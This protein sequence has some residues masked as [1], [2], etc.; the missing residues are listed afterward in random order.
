MDFAIKRNRR[1]KDNVYLVWLLSFNES[2]I[3]IK[4]RGALWYPSIRSSLPFYAGY[5]FMVVRH[6]E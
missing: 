6:I 3:K 2:E 1:K 4:E 5:I